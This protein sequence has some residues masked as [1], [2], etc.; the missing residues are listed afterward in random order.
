MFFRD[1]Q[2]RAQG[3]KQNISA[4]KK[5][6]QVDGVDPRVAFQDAI[7]VQKKFKSSQEPNSG[8]LPYL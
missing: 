7:N 2:S 3:M 5:V 4:L 8:S 6:G 1:I